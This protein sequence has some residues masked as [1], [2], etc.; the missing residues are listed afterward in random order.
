MIFE[1]MLAVLM[2]VFF[3]VYGIMHATN[4]EVVWMQPIAA[5]CALIA[6]VLLILR[7]VYPTVVQR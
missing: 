4:I 2:G 7:A 1:R 3:I 5:I 6:G